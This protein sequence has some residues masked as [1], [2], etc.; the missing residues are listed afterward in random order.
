MRRRDRHAEEAPPLRHVGIEVAQ[1]IKTGGQSKMRAF[2]LLLHH[3]P[4][5]YRVKSF[6]F[7]IL[8][9]ATSFN[10]CSRNKGFGK[11]FFL[12]SGLRVHYFHY[13]K[14]NSLQ[15]FEE[16]S[17][18]LSHLF[19][20][21]RSLAC[22]TE[23]SVFH[24]KISSCEDGSDLLQSLLSVIKAGIWLPDRILITFYHV[25]GGAGVPD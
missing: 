3:Q 21:P 15:H 25:L 20:L 13:R 16:V 12:L 14:E 11:S 24:S 10:K 2:A 9:M 1:S 5:K 23:T 19:Y 22:L 17:L 6:S 7:Q 4:E 8:S 18:I